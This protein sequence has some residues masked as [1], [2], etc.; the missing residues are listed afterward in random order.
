MKLL[1][2][3]PCGDM[4]CLNSQSARKPPLSRLTSPLLPSMTLCLCIWVS[5]QL[6]ENDGARAAHLAVAMTPPRSPCTSSALLPILTYQVARRQVS[7][8][9]SRKW[10]MSREIFTDLPDLRPLAEHASLLPG[11]TAPIFSPFVSSFFFFHFFS[12]IF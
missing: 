3:P 9:G 12:G 4:L 11:S 1:Q 6:R 5:V 2:P 7:R 8:R 10:P